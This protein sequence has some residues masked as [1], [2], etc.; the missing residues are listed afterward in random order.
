MP[1][2]VWFSGSALVFFK[3]IHRKIL[4]ITHIKY[5]KSVIYFCVICFLSLLE[6]IFMMY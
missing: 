3:L 1:L 2:A 6:V 5:H 4:I